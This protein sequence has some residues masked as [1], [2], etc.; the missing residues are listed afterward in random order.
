M[1][2]AETLHMFPTNNVYKRV[3]GARDSLYFFFLRLFKKLSLV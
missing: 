1:F 3:K 2:F